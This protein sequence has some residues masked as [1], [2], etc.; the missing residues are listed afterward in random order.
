M[1]QRGHGKGGGYNFFYGE[2]RKNHQ[3]RTGFFLHHRITAAARRIY[4]LSDR[5]PR[6]V[7]T[8]HWCNII[9]LNVHAPSKIRV[10]IQTTVFTRK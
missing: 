7:L 6:I 9:V 1:R 5:V 10:V 8:G 3:L 4:F 2:G